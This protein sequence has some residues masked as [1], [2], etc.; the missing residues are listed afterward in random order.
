MAILKRNRSRTISKQARCFAVATSAGAIAALLAASPIV[1]QTSTPLPSAGD[2]RGG[3]APIIEPVP[4]ILDA[5]FDNGDLGPD[6]QKELGITGNETLWFQWKIKAAAIKGRWEIS[7][8]NGGGLLAQGEVPAAKNLGDYAF[9]VIDFA[10]LDLLPPLNVRIQPLTANGS[11]IGAISPPVLLKQYVSSGDVTCFTDGGLRLPIDDKLEAIR[12]AHAVPALGGAV[13]TT[14][15]ME[16]FDAVGIRKITANPNNVTKY[17]KWHLGSDTKAMTSMLVGILRQYYPSTVGWNTTVA[18]A[19]PEW[20]GT[21]DATIAKTTLRQLLAH[22]SGLYLFSEDQ[23]AKLWEANQSVT[24]QRRN[25]TH[26]VVLDPHFLVPGV[27][28]QY[29]NANFI[30]AGAMLENLFNNSWENLI[31]QYLF[32]PLGMTSAGFGGPAANAQPQPWGHYDKNGM[33]TPTDGDNI[34]SLGPA[35]TVHTSLEDWGKFIRLYLTGHEGGVTLTAST[36]ATLMT[37]YTSSD[38]WFVVWPQSY[39]WGWF[40]SGSGDKVLSHDGANMSWYARA[41]VNVDKGYALL[42][43]SNSASLGSINPAMEAMD[44]TVAMLEKYHSGC[45][46]NDRPTRVS[47]PARR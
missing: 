29:E 13:V 20:A 27:S 25:F 42:A 18:D 23:Y 26:A 10:P 4:T 28:F 9:F 6:W 39:G 35:G 30:I 33:Y 37:A 19:F 21:M 22:R 8:P 46:D 11:P 47:A 43:V 15:G 40:V 1:A 44:D 17:D 41:V 31:T 12:A 5:S 32:Q 24:Q 14:Y 3:S 2:Q 16:V 36:R 38:P 7:D 45:P 34:P